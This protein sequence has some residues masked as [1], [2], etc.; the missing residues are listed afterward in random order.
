MRECPSVLDKGTFD[1]YNGGK[2]LGKK[3]VAG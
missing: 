3:E 1:T 2:F